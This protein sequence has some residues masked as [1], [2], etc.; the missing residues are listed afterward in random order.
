M[1]GLTIATVGAFEKLAPGQMAATIKVITFSVPEKAVARAE[2][3]LT[4]NGGLISVA[5]FAR[6]V[7]GLV[8]TQVAGTKPSVL[9]KRRAGH[10]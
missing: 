10:W 8:L 6:K 1:K 2:E 3:L 5:P 9:E 4:S 7:A